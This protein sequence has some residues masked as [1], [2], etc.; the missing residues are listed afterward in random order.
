MDITRAADVLRAGGLAPNL[1]E[2]VRIV[3][4]DPVLPTPFPVGEVAAA[5]VGLCGS[6]AAELHRMR[7]GVDQRVSVDVRHAAASLLGFAYQSVDGAGTPRTNA[8]NP[9]V[10][11]HRCADGWIHLHGGFPA[12]DAGT[13]R[14]LGVAA[15]AAHREITAATERWPAQELEDA[16][17]AEGLCGARLRRPEEWSAHEQG[18]AIAGLQVV[19]IERIGDADPPRWPAAGAGGAGRPLSGLRVLDAT[20]V[21]AGPTCG[22]TL[23]EHGA[24]V[25]RIGSPRLP[26]VAP[27]VIDTG[28]GKR[29]AFADLDEPA[30]RAAFDELLREADVLSVGY[31]AGSFER[32]GLGPADVAA[33]RPGIVYVSVNAYGHVGPWRERPGWEQLAQTATGVAFVQGTAVAGG[34]PEQE[35]WRPQLL[36]AAA[37]DYTTGYLAAYGAMAALTRRAQEGGSWHVRVSLSQTAMWL[38]RLGADLDHAAAPGIGDPLDLQVGTPSPF[39]RL[40]HLRPVA[41]L[42][43]TP[44]RWD[45]PPA[46]LGSHPPRWW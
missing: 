14:V 17:A 3:G 30:G 16:L 4:A 15:D 13:R 7:T 28:H 1:L 41:Q 24:D 22:R 45:L 2:G 10:A 29:S 27:F 11:F 18:V 32:R 23:A 44:A 9:T 46:E 35:G 12:L 39:G 42:S 37:T 21:L 31:R 33:T 25:L 26:S 20:R 38:L 6:Q 5:A 36:P 19:E 43:R 8:N 40:L 34:G